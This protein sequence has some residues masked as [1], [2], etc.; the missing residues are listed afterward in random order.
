MSSRLKAS[1]LQVGG[2]S[3]FRYAELDGETQT[4]L[5]TWVRERSV[6]DGEVI[7]LGAVYRW[8]DLL[9]KFS[10]PTDSLRDRFRANAAIRSVRAY[11]RIAPIRS[12][13]PIVA[14]AGPSGLLVTEFVEGD[15]VER[16]WQSEP[17]SMD[18][19]VEFLAAMHE[20]HVFHGDFH[21]HNMIWSGEEWYLIDLEG[22]RH[23]LR[24]MFPK[25]LIEDHWAR[26]HFC[27][28]LAPELE[29]YFHRYLEIAALDW[30]PA[31]AWKRVTELS[32]GMSDAWPLV[33]M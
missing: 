24:T 13:K 7:K 23:P 20:H 12:P 26:L 1:P 17:A 4:A 25:R 28:G 8:R 16:I 30:S 14:M 15:F 19:L 21:A 29:G 3:G 32:R 6:P 18:R 11:E 33:E 27:L 5:E 31:L 9:V 10:P 2:E 22:L